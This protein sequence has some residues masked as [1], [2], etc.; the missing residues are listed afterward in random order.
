MQDVLNM[1]HR[2]SAGQA[3][4]FLFGWVICFVT[5][6]V[7]KAQSAQID[8]L[9]RVV[10]SPE[11]PDSVKLVALS[12][13]DGLIYRDDPELDQKLN[14][15]MDSICRVNLA[16]DLPASRLT[17]FQTALCRALNNGGI[18]LKNKGDFSGALEKY[19]ESVEI[20][21]QLEDHSGV[22]NTMNN[23]GNIYMH[24]K[25]YEL[26]LDFFDQ[27]LA[28]RKRMHDTLGI[29]ECYNNMAS[30]FRLQGDLSEAL[31]N[32]RLSDSLYQV[33]EVVTEG[34]IV[35]ISNLGGCYF[36]LGAHGMAMRLYQR[37]LKEAKEIGSR[38]AEAVAYK[39]LGSGHMR[40]GNDQAAVANLL[41]A[42]QVTEQIDD[43]ITQRQ[44]AE[45]LYKVYSRMGQYAKALRMHERYVALNDSLM[46]A[47]NQREVLQYKYRYLYEK[48]AASD[49]IKFVSD[50]LEAAKALEMK[51][52]QMAVQE[53]K[54]KERG[55]QI[56]FLI[57]GLCLIGLIAGIIYQRWSVTKMEKQLI[58]KQKKLD[59]SFVI[60]DNK[61]RH[62]FEQ[63]LLRKLEDLKKLEGQELKKRF[64]EY[65]IDL[66]NQIRFEKKLD[67]LSENIQ[68]LHGEF[69]LNLRERF[70]DL[71]PS[72]IEICHMFRLN[73]SVK[74]IASM[75]GTSEGA[76]RTA[77]YRIKSK[78]GLQDES[79]DEYIKNAL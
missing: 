42:I 35:T 50:S 71:T 10:R 5:P 55:Y 41:K 62:E 38:R 73:M 75:K 59:L 61:V 6:Q 28:I 54:I 22:S 36:D 19:L 76:I 69:E 1:E 34:S 49:R 43:V 53:S 21:K 70:P 32:F 14:E 60:S 66:K 2:R 63:Q 57:G 46:G 52:A 27:S 3:F 79:L 40:L 72:E 45:S 18:V 12:R 56:G 15:R 25:E 29:A 8:S 23:I 78:L 39:D 37:A 24:Q 4:L 47:E 7:G 33:L 31:T 17:F 44:A 20:K 48:K 26:S 9:K 77:R 11:V 68:E 30:V 67:H 64:N 51:D 74:E 16:K 58:E 65:I 13:W